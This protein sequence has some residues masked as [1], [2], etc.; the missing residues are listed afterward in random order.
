MLEES[1]LRFWN[2]NMVS[3]DRDSCLML[4]EQDQLLLTF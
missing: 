2:L 1:V 4:I 3:D